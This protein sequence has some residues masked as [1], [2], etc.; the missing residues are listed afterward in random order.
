MESIVFQRISAKLL[1]LDNPV[2]SLTL[3]F[4]LWKALVFLAI[5]TCPGPG[6]DTSTTLIRREDLTPGP[7]DQTE[8][9]PLPLRFARWDSIYF[10]H[11]AE[12]G[13]VFEQ[14]WAFGYPRLLGLFISGK[15]IPEV[16]WS[17]I[18][19]HL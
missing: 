2:R 19:H 12:Q 15:S 5:V 18:T 6:Y 3:A 9:L 4:W 8:L 11:A 10:L 17:K 1:R 7:W 13:Y 16:N 14:E